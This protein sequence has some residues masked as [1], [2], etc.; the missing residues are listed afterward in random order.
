MRNARVVTAERREEGL[1]DVVSKGGVLL[2]PS[3]VAG[4]LD[5]R[6]LGVEGVLDVE[7]SELANGEFLAIVCDNVSESLDYAGEV[8]VQVRLQLVFRG[9]V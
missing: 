5:R 8:L 2:L 4:L 1:L 9:I 6:G 3:V 7:R